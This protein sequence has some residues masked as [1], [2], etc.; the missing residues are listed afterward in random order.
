[1]A[2]LPDVL[3]ANLRVVFCGTA[4]G[5][6]SAE[7][8]AY[9]AGPGNRFWPTLHEIGLTPRQ[10][11]PAE[12]HDV[13]A[14]G[15]GLTDIVKTASGGDHELDPGDFDAVGLRAKMWRHAPLALAFNGKHSAKAFFGTNKIEYG[16][17]T[18]ALGGTAL[19]VLPSTS[20]AARRYWDIA[21]WRGLAA[22]LMS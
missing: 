17:Q 22:F 5:R 20:A 16:R 6:K 15:I 9:Y 4:A 11:A 18:E 13:M 8:G 14:F 1:V 3:A 21:P 12:F 2:V 19:F 7:V 10:L